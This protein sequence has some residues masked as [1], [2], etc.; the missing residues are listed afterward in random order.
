MLDLAKL[1]RQ[2]QALGDA[3]AAALRRSG[4]EL[5]RARRELAR[6]TEA[7]EALAAKTE[8]A[9]TSWLVARLA[10]PPGEAVPPPPR[11]P[12]V[13]VIATDGSQ[14][15][16]DHHEGLAAYLLN[17]GTVVLHYGEPAPGG[18]RGDGADRAPGGG[19]GLREGPGLRGEDPAGRAAAGAEPD[20]PSGAAVGAARLES[21]PRLCF[22]EADL[23]VTVAG[24]RV[25]VEGELLGLRRSLEEL[26]HLARLAEAARAEGRAA[27][28]GF[29][30]GSL[31]R[32]SVASRREVPEAFLDRY[33]AEFE[34][35]RAAG[36]PLVGYISQSRS[37]DV[38]NALRVQVCPEPV[39]DCDRCPYVP[40]A[41]RPKADPGWAGPGLPC[42]VIAGVVDRRLFAGV[43]REGERTPVFGSRSSVLERYGEH[44]V[45]FC[46]LNVGPEVARLEFPR[47]VTRD[48]ALLDLVHAVSLDQ[49][50]K[51]NGYPVA[52]AEAHQRAVVRAPERALFYQLV[53][54]ALV[55]RGVT[56]WRS[57]KVLH[58]VGLTV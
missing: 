34:R 47:W 43:L 54:E 50:R 33:L 24:R 5:A 1:C 29:V 51:G 55:K 23:A 41:A 2:I 39:P 7:P 45:D 38:I 56:R 8:R 18:G 20:E 27:V 48:P 16:P 21:H 52:L 36:V 4:E 58:K 53:E 46:Y 22:E 13:T 15:E 9:R 12:R 35:L 14:I 19:V 17:V 37:A 28:V 44:A 32:W 10:G 31:I 30:D 40:G 26:A 25:P 49:A 3:E 57:P 42:E 6:A 11:P